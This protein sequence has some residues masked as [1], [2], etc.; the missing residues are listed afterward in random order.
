MRTRRLVRAG[1]AF[2]PTVED[3]ET[4]LSR[5]TRKRVTAFATVL[6]LAACGGGIA[7]SAQA[8]PPTAGAPPVAVPSEAAAVDVLVLQKAF[9]A[10]RGSSMRQHQVE[11]QVAGSGQSLQFSTRQRMDVTVKRPNRFRSEMTMVK[12]DGS[13]GGRYVVVSDGAQVWIHRPGMKQYTV[14]PRARFEAARDDLTVLGLVGLLFFN[15]E[16]LGGISAM[17]PENKEA[18]LADLTKAGMRL[19]GV[20]ESVGG[21]DYSVFTLEMPKEGI[22]M[23]FFVEPRNS[24]I[25]QMEMTI[26]DKSTD[27]VIKEIVRSQTPAPALTAS[28]FRF[29]PPRGDKQ[30]K[31]LPVEP[32]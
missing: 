6:G 12:P 2:V 1:F 18:V 14:V 21:I 17:T 29:T 24:T 20:K 32:F 30:V 25:R 4:T 23:R 3:E 9:N 11:M 28:T 13:T 15:D 19:S 26:K 5:A 7:L 16:L 8:T 31:E 10:L 27:I 22:T